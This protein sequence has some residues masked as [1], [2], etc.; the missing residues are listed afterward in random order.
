MPTVRRSSVIEDVADQLHPGDELLVVCDT[1]EDPVAAHDGDFPDGAR[2]VVAGEPDG[3]SGKANAVAAGIEAARHDRIVLT[4][5]DYHH[6]PDWLDALHADYERHG[7]TSEV[8]F[9]VGN[10]L[11][12]ML[13]EPHYNVSNV[14]GLYEDDNPWGGTVVFDRTEVDEAALCAELRQTVSDDGVIN[15]YLSFTTVKRV[16]RVAVGGT[17]RETLERHVRFVKITFSYMSL[18][19]QAAYT[20]SWLL[21]ALALLWFPIPGAVLTTVAA[22]AT[23]AYIGVHRWTFVLAYP[24]LVVG[25]PLLVYAIARRTFVWGGRRYRWVDRDDVKIVETV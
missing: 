21:T 17:F 15:E 18:R 23:Y 11:L 20:G 14:V 5:D 4:D 10:D 8:P 16:R 2:L 7:P 9:F 13:L 3:C 22:G 6:P 1:P 12:S 24:G 19:M 25:A